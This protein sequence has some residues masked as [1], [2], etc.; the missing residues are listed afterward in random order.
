M[1]RWYST[2]VRARGPASAGSR[3]AEY[4]LPRDE[5]VIEY[6]ERFKH[7]ML[8]REGTFEGFAVAGSVGRDVE[9]QSGRIDKAPGTR[10]RS[11]SHRGL[12]LGSVGRLVRRR[13]R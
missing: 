1:K 12:S 4:S 10:P 7:L 11:R 3:H 5:D 6:R 8:A 2:N 9:L 13:W